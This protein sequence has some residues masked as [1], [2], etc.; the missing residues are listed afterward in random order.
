M[1]CFFL[2]FIQQEQRSEV[3]IE[4]EDEVQENANG[5]GCGS[6]KGTLLFL[7]RLENTYVLP[8]QMYWTC[9]KLLVKLMFES[10]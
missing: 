2:I 8:K 4:I 7:L 9:V 1:I 6:E 3:V 10:F 5:V